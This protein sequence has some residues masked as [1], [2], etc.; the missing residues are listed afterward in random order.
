MFTWKCTNNSTGQQLFYNTQR[1]A[2]LVFIQFL[3]RCVCI[4][5]CNETSFCAFP[6]ITTQVQ[7]L[8]NTWNFI[9]CSLAFEVSSLVLLLNFQA[10]VQLYTFSYQDI[11]CMISTIHMYININLQ[12]FLANLT[13]QRVIESSQREYIRMT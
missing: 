8:N 3:Q 12:M 1:I 13:I 6:K 5:H 7:P 4:I 2:N 10:I 9:S 11:Y